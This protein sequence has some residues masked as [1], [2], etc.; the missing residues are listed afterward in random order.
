MHSV[1]R[2][3]IERLP[4][5]VTNGLPS[6]VKQ[7][8][9]ARYGDDKVFD[10]KVHFKMRDQRSLSESGHE[11]I[12]LD[13]AISAMNQYCP[14]RRIDRSKIKLERRG[15]LSPLHAI[16]TEAALHSHSMDDQQVADALH[17]YFNMAGY[18]R[19]EEVMITAG[20]AYTSGRCCTAD[21]NLDSLPAPWGFKKPS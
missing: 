21:P 2:G 6:S 18:N 3:F 13:A 9:F 10:L 11:K 4:G 15:L 8:Y 19:I 14:I 1:Y 20:M 17:W 5:R 7:A 12:I 16:M